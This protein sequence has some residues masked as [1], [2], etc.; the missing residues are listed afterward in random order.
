MHRPW[1]D[2]ERPDLAN[3]PE[4]KKAAKR[5]ALKRAK[6]AS[7]KTFVGVERAAAPKVTLADLEDKWFTLLDGDVHLKSGTRTAY[8]SCWTSNGKPRLL[9]LRDFHR[10][11][12]PIL[13]PDAR[14]SGQKPPKG[15]PPAVDAR[16]TRRGSR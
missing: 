5:L 13:R 1:V 9:P 2:L 14:T 3:T 7:K 10:E 16:A 15:R 11:P 4:D 6:L 12:Q 8:K